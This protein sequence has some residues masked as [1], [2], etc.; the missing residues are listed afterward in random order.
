MISRSLSIV[1]LVLIGVFPSCSRS[2]FST[3]SSAEQESKNATLVEKYLRFEAKFD[4]LGMVR[5]SNSGDKVFLSNRNGVSALDSLTGEVVWD[6]QLGLQAPPELIVGK[7][8]RVYVESAPG[9]LLLLNSQSGALVTK[10]ELKEAKGSYRELVDAFEVDDGKAIIVRSGSRTLAKINLSTGERHEVLGL[11]ES[12]T[13]FGGTRVP[14]LTIL[15][16]ADKSVVFLAN[17]KLASVDLESGKARLLDENRKFQHGLYSKNLDANSCF[18]VSEAKELF[19]VELES[20]TVSLTL[21]ETEFPNSG[22]RARIFPEEKLVVRPGGHTKL[23]K[24]ALVFQKEKPQ[25][26][27]LWGS[28]GVIDI[29]SSLSGKCFLTFNL[30][31]EIAVWNTVPRAEE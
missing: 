22:N 6:Y 3:S 30:S 5:F 13:I 2:S 14:I 1:V 12:A 4:G 8:D 7:G 19:C 27:I 20:K 24:F 17:G 29:Q 21:L 9:E 15:A 25:K 26:E 28:I 31:G 23:G 18:I 16:A 11:K 10:F